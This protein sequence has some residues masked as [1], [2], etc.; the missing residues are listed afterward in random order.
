MKDIIVYI[1]AAIFAIGGFFVYQN[2]T[3]TNS[4]ISLPPLDFSKMPAIAIAK[5][6]KVLEPALKQLGVKTLMAKLVEESNGGTTY[7]CHQE[8]HNIGRIGYKIYKEKAFGECDANCHS[9]CYHGAM[10][11]FLNEKGTANLS[12]NIDGVCG[13]FKTTFGNFECLHGVGHGL[14][15]YLDYDMPGTVDECKKLKDTFSV[16]SCYGG[17][18]MENVLTAQGL[19]ASEKPGHETKWANKTD[20]LF[21]CNALPESDY[22]LQYQC[23]QMQTSWMLTMFN[24]N[25]SKVKDECLKAPENM[26]AVCFK[27]FGRDAAGNSLRNPESIKKTCAMVPKIKDYYEQCIVGGVNVIVDFW[28]PALKGQAAELCKIL[29]GTGKDVCYLTLASRL[30]QL[31]TTKEEQIAICSTFEADYQKYCA[32]I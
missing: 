3:D 32:T 14:L 23:Y 29:T 10:E 28:G 25:F 27:S 20:P 18:F 24:Y 4:N 21:P 30:P 7:D 1:S 6:D 9:G 31:F 22:N 12:A 15:A 17:M 8:A 2:L 26:I 5:N 16:D 19:G 11:K 13:L